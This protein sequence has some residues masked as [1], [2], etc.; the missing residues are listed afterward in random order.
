MR[1][2]SVG[3]EQIRRFLIENHKRGAELY[4]EDSP[5][6]K[7]FLSAWA[8][9]AEQS[10]GNGSGPSIELRAWDSVSGIT[11][12]FVV[13]SDGIDEDDEQAE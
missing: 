5:E 2:N 1:I 4:S 7:K 6:S 8:D 12:N 3:V 9:Q 13:G 10:A 11:Q